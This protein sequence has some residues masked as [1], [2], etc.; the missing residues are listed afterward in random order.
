M[1]VSNS[2]VVL[3]LVNSNSKSAPVAE[4]VGV[5]L[6]VTPTR[7]AGPDRPSHRIPR[8]VDDLIHSNRGSLT[9]AGLLK[10]YVCLYLHVHVCFRQQ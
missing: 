8:A 6:M 10:R 9:T 7:G 3:E 2:L 4:V 1:L 5:D